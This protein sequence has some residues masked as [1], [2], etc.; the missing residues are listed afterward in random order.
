MAGRRTP[1][2]NATARQGASFGDWAGWELPAS[3]GDLLA[4]YKAACDGDADHDSSYMG[5]VKGTGEDVLDLL[6]RLSTN[7]V[8]SLEA[9]QGAPTVLTTDR[10]RILDLITVLN[11]GDHI[12]L[13]T[14]PQA[15]QDVIEWI[16]KYTI[17]DDVEFEDVTSSTAMVSVIGP[18]GPDILG[19]LAG[20]ELGTFAPHQ[21]AR[22]AIAGAEGYIVRRDLADLTRCEVVVKSHDSEMV[23]Q[24]I[25]GVGVTPVGLEVSEVLRVERALPG[26][27]GELGESYNPLE[28]G[29]WGSISFTKGCYI[30]QEVIARLDTYQKVQKHLVSFSFSP[31]ARIEAGI[32]LA[33]EGR[34]VGQVTSV[35]KVPTTGELIGLGYVRKEA[36]EVGTQISLAE[37]AGSWAKVEAQALPFGPGG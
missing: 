8:V 13:L 21:S 17:V 1:L 37:E 11:L 35:V 10:G 9:G 30:G 7:A 25:I 5:R 15:S 12:Q 24:E 23:W 26:H 34:E 2:Y 19:S 18:K 3:Y 27:D 4:E 28:T 6:H 29:L 20:I 16:D 32:K 31:D 22:V 33:K 14:G 36:A